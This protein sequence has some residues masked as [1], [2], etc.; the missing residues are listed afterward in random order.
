MESNSE[1]Q[2][3]NEEDPSPPLSQEEMEAA[4]EW[5]S[6]RGDII[7]EL[8]TIARRATQLERIKRIL[9]PYTA[10]SNLCE[11]APFRDTIL[12]DTLTNEEKANR[13]MELYY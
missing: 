11:L 4:A 3:F 6:V 8:E 13:L 2:L 10:I 1:P 9:S 12:E 5:E 7:R